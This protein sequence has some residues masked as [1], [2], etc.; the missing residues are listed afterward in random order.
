MRAALPSLVLC[1]LV[2]APAAAV[3]TVVLDE[4][5]PAFYTLQG[6]VLLAERKYES[7]LAQYQAALAIDPQH[8]PAIFNM[9]LACQRLGRMEEARRW[10]EQALRQRPDHHEVICNLGVLAFAAGDYEQAARRFQD[11]AGL[12]ATASPLDAADYWFNLGTARERL[13][14]YADAR[15]AYE[16]ALQIQAQHAAAHYNL[17]SLYLGPLAEEPEAL[18]KAIAHLEAARSAEPRLAVAWVNLGLAYERA[19]RPADAEAALTRALEL[20]VGAERLQVRWQRVRWYLRQ[21][22]PRRLAARDELL[23]IL[24]EQPDF[25]E[26]NGLLGQYYF[27]IGDYDQALRYLTRE[28]EGPAF[29]AKSPVDRECHYLLA[30]IYT[31]HRPDAQRATTHASAYYQLHPDAPKIHALRRRVFRLGEQPARR[32]SA[33]ATAARPAAP[34]PT[35]PALE[36]AP[37]IAPRPSHAVTGGGH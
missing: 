26:A 23:A 17:G 35:A 25:P 11:A 5:S 18:S 30:L 33:E 6:N 12:A 1:L 28:I 8:F 22:P 3:E 16:S 9:A 31:D 21:V 32:P 36:P 19:D 14:L 20:A 15:R 24:N 27:Q 4:N 34:A 13:G 37:A 29:D 7:A 10:Y 2:G